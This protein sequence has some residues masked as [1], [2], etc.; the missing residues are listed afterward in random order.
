M[1]RR[2]SSL[3][4]GRLPRGRQHQR[5]YQ[6]KPARCQPTTV[7]DLTITRTSAYRDQ[8]CSRIVQNSR[9]REFRGGRSLSLANYQFMALDRPIFPHFSAVASRSSS[10]AT[11]TCSACGAAPR[12]CL[13]R[14]SSWRISHRCRSIFPERSPQTRINACSR[15]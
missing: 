13:R 14:S 7:L 6:R 4:F 10:K 3:I 5:Q 8:S 1:R 15:N 12:L 2:I 9:S 11:V